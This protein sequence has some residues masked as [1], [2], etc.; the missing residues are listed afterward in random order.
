LSRHDQQLASHPALRASNFFSPRIIFGPQAACCP[1]MCVC[2]HAEE[3]CCLHTD[4][5]IRAGQRIMPTRIVCVNCA[6]SVGRRVAN[7]DA[8][9]DGQR[10]HIS[11]AYPTS[12]G[13]Q[14]TLGSHCHTTTSNEFS[15]HR[16]MQG[17]CPNATAAPEQ[18]TDVSQ[19]STLPATTAIDV[20]QLQ[21][22]L[23]QQQTPC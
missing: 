20:S 19:H 23:S 10:R 4:T 14:S 17:M 6:C 1:R 2:M 16:I 15:T 12:A 18:V 21:R 11:G 7:D 3:G 22:A 13:M 8:H 5:H 9:T